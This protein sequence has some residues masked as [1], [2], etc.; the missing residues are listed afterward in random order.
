MLFIADK[1]DKIELEL[2]QKTKGY[3]SKAI[4]ENF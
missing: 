4:D 1:E 2:F 3:Q